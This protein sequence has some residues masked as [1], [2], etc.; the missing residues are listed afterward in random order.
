MHLQLRLGENIL[1]LSPFFLATER[2]RHQ[3][4]YKKQINKA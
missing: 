4:S 1:K 3:N 2:E